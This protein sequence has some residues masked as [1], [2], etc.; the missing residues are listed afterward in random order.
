[1]NFIH[2][3][4]ASSSKVKA[5]FGLHPTVLAE[6]L[7][8]VLPE[9]ERRRSERLAQRPDRKRAL[10]ADD[11][12]PREVTPLHKT[13]MTLLY[14]R[15]NVSHT[16]VGALFGHSAD[17]AENAFHELLPVL[18]D[19]FPKEKW[20]AEKRPRTK[21]QWT[22]DEVE[23]LLLDSFETPV[24]RPSLHERQKRLY[25]GKKKRHTLKTQ[26]ITDQKGEILDVSRAHRGPTADVKLFAQTPLPKALQ[27][28]PRLGDKAYVGAD[29]VIQTP[30]KKPKGGALTEAQ[31][32]ENRHL[33]SQRVRVEH[34]IRR[35]KGFRITR[36]DYRLAVGLFPAVVSAVVGLLQFS[37]IVG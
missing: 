4:H 34:G 36:D 22:P 7:F 19:L 5:L 11:G 25:S 14:L 6:L 18:R 2:L 26:I 16:V 28:K 37:R 31:K 27:D 10:V 24:A 33:S 12:R 9:L 21:P 15:H 20:E 8:K 23:R 1:M 32:A 17:S 3:K 35:V 29:P 13:L 30:H